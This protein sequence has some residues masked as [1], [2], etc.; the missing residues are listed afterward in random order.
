MKIYKLAVGIFL[1]VAM[2]SSGA[3]YY[4]YRQNDTQTQQLADYHQQV[5]QL[6]A[7]IEQGT[8]ER[9]EFEK[10]IEAMQ[11]NLLSAANQSKVL[12]SELEKIREMVNPDYAKV[13]QEIRRRVEREYRDTSALDN[14]ES[15]ASLVRKLANLSN[16]ERMAMLSVQGQY[17]GFLEALD[18]SPQR[19][20][21]VSQALIDVTL[22]QNQARQDLLASD[23][24]PVEIREELI[25]IMSPEA[26]SEALAFELT[27]EEIAMFESYRSQMT[28]VIGGV[29]PGGQVFRFRGSNDGDPATATNITEF[30]I[31][32][33]TVPGTS[34]TLQLQKLSLE[35]QK[36]ADQ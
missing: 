3:A 16:D 17:G 28:Q 31:A 9:L 25:S 35:D 5:E 26:V 19:L 20:E 15:A 11:N 30:V 32:P 22:A 7:K 6:L 8:R 13:E 18:A 12:S 4:L 2:I 34:G 27:E 33:G 23:L 24:Q 1:G 36:E 14:T 29:A 21:Q 10:Q